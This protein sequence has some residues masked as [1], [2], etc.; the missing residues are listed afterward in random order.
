MPKFSIDQKSARNFCLLPY[1]GNLH[2]LPKYEFG[3]NFGR[4]WLWGS[5]GSRNF[6]RFVRKFFPSQKVMHLALS[7]LTSIEKKIVLTNKILLLIFL[8]CYINPN[9]VWCC[10]PDTWLLI[11]DCKIGFEFEH[12]WHKYF[13]SPVRLKCVF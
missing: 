8:E 10:L 9:T 1:F 2:I 13:P 7:I 6:W 12:N 4:F 11:E 5:P 3:E